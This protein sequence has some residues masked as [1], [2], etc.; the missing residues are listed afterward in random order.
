MES[1]QKK[2]GGGFS[3]FKKKSFLPDEPLQEEE[4]VIE[5]END[6]EN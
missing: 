3:C 2:E 4:Q 1:P 6:E 5:G